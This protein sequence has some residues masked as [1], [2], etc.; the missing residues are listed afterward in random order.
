MPCK[1]LQKRL[2]YNRSWRKRNPQKVK[3][4]NRK[5][6]IKHPW[7]TRNYYHQEK[8]K[9]WQEEYSKKYYQLNKQQIR[10]RTKQRN[11][12]IK[13]ECLI[14]YGGNPPKCVCCGEAI[15]EFLT[16]DHVNEDGN[17]MRMVHGT[18]NS[19]HGW[20]IKNN[21]PKGF[22]ILCFNCNCAKG[23]FGYCPHQKKRC[24]K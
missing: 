12:R 8:W 16:I 15:L 13:M 1:N 11:R 5:F 4:Y 18:G 24:S 19:F 2:A 3:E 10:E 22:Q 23:F 7:W 6:N 17:K 21:F 14:A 9:K 20:L